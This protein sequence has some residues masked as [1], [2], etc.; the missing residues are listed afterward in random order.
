M[1]QL[2]PEVYFKLLSALAQCKTLDEL[3]ALEAE[4]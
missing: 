3:K 2:K 4:I 1:L